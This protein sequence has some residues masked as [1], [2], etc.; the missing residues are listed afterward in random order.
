MHNAAFKASGFDGVYTAFEVADLPSALKG[1]R[2]LGIRGVSVTIPH[3]VSVIPLLDEVDPTAMKIGAVNTV[4]SDGGV[5]KGYNTDCQGA[6]AALMEKS[7]VPGKR[8]LIVGA[9]GAARAIGFGLTGKRARVTFCNRTEKKAERLAGE[10][11]A[12]FCRM[13]EIGDGEWEIIIN[14]TSVGMTPHTKHMPIPETLLRPGQ[15]VM[16]IVYNPLETLLLKKAAQAG[17]ITVDGAAM[18]VHQGAFQFEL[19]TGLKAPIQVMEETVH[20][21]LKK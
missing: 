4:V 17:C 8:V 16:D 7:E 15:C 14:T 10:L 2:A 18:F 11:G 9:G 20:K 6:V 19:W 5:L 3:K 21:A 12:A 13:E 1:I